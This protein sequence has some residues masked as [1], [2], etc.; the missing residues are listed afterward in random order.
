MGA[1]FGLGGLLLLPIIVI[2]GGPIFA[3][4]GNLAVVA[5]LAVVPMFVGYLLFGRGLVTV[6][7]ST[8]T[9]VSLLEP[10]VAALI[11]VIILGEQLPPTGWLGLG[12]VFISLFMTAASGHPTPATSRTQSMET[13]DAKP[14]AGTLPSITK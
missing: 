13:G 12:L 4:T 3:S 1:T 9:T 2:T 8:A 5:Y 10:A 14:T 11:A 6:S 7:A